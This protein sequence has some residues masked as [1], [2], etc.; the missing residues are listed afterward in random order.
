M[1][2]L[3]TSTASPAAQ[4]EVGPWLP[5]LLQRLVAMPSW[6]LLVPALLPR[7]RPARPCCRASRGSACKQVVGQEW[8]SQRTDRQCV[9]SWAR[10]P[11]PGL[12]HGSCC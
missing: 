12:L 11:P 4:S 9:C 7:Q 5:L 2:P 8:R 10:G 3:K 1:S 6:L